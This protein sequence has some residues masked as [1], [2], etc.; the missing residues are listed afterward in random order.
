MSLLAAVRRSACPVP[1][2]ANWPGGLGRMLVLCMVSAWLAGC[3]PASPPAPW[4]IAVNPWVGYEPLVLAQETGTLPPAMRV[5]ELASNTETKRA[6]RNGLIEL[7]AL[8]LDEALRLADEGE[9]LHIVAVL[10]DSAGADA[11]LARADVA[12][13]LKRPATAPP[14]ATPAPNRLRRSAVQAGPQR[15]RIGL[16]R[17]ALGELMLAHWLEHSRLS[18]A[19]VQPIHIEAADHEAALSNREV[20]VLVTFEPMKTRL[21]Q[22]GAVNL[23]DTRSL[24]GEVVDVLVARPGLDASRLAALLHAWSSARQ[25]LVDASAPPE[26]LAAGLDLTSTQYLQTLNGLRFLP[27]AEMS[28]R[29]QPVSIQGEPATAPLARDSQHTVATLQRLGLLRQ[30]PDWVRLLDAE[31]L[32]QALASQPPAGGRP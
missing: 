6:F 29:L 23:L 19:D 31:P 20:D 28:V 4:R 14:A 13:R 25:R 26:W 5:V 16:E 30:P 18:L 3:G 7:A 12:A 2:P 8:T 1:W 11:V 21:E 15:L 32:V 10:S 17:T 24:P 27:L 9:A 22:S